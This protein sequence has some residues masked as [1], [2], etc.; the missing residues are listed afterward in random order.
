[1]RWRWQQRG[2]RSRAERLRREQREGRVVWQGSRSDLWDRATDVPPLENVLK[3]QECSQQS[4][5][6]RLSVSHSPMTL[7]ES[8]TTTPVHRH[9]QEQGHSQLSRAITT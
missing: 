3:G 5:Y 2:D 7:L 8:W 4:S 9:I 6:S 1:M